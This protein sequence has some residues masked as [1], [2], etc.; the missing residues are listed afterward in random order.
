[1]QDWESDVSEMPRLMFDE[2]AVLVCQLDQRSYGQGFQL[3]PP[4]LRS[5]LHRIVPAI[6]KSNTAFVRV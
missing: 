2:L 5:H 3:V 6:P 4:D 1:M